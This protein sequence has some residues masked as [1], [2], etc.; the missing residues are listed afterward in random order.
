MK[1]FYEDPLAAAWQTK[2][3]GM[4]FTVPRPLLSKIGLDGFAAGRYI[5]AEADASGQYKLY[6]HPD[7]LHLLEPMV[8]DV[9][10]ADLINWGVN[11]GVVKRVNE[12]NVM[13]GALDWDGE[14]TVMINSKDAADNKIIQRN[15]IQFHFPKFENEGE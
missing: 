5:F 2:H 9:M 14:S 10:T 15:N 13:I 7:S 11:V 4:Q 1:P 3:F 8:G 12:N 6:L